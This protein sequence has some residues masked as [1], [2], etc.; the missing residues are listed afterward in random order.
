MSKITTI[1]E[2]NNL[3][4]EYYNRLTPRIQHIDDERVKDIVVC[5]GS[6]CKFAGCKMIANRFKEKIQEN[7]LEDKFEVVVTGCA[8]FCEQGP[9]AKISYDDTLYVKLTEDLVD[10]IIEEHI[11]N[12]NLVKKAL[13]KDATTKMTISKIDDIP[14]YKNQYR[15][16]LQNIGTIDP[17]KITEYIGVDGYQGFAK[18]LLSMSSEDINDE[19]VRSGLQGRGSNGI[20]VGDRW[21]KAKESKCSNKIVVCKADESDPGAYLQ[22][23]II[24]GNPHSIIEAILICGKAIGAKKGVVNIMAKHKKSVDVFTNA[25]KQAREF[26]LLGEN[27]LGCD[28]SFDIF[29]QLDE[30]TFLVGEEEDELTTAVGKRSEPKMIKEDLAN[31]VE[32]LNIT[33]TVETLAN[34]PKI[35]FEGGE[36]FAKIGNGQG[37]GTKVFSLTG[38]INNVGLV[39]VPIGTTLKEVIYN[40]GGGIKSGRAFKAIQVGGP[41]GGSLYYKNLDTPID[42]YGVESRNTIMGTGGLV[43]LDQGDCIINSAKYYIDY[44]AEE[45]CGKCTACRI[46]NTRLSE[47]LE[48]ITTGKSS[49]EEL[50]NLK[51][52]GEFIKDCSLC[53]VGQNSP[54]PVLSSLELFYD[55]YIEHTIY[56]KC[57]SGVC[58]ELL[59]YDIDNDRCIGC[60]ICAKSCPTECISGKSKGPHMI[61]QTNC[62]K[63]GICFS[64]CPKNAVIRI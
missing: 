42:F 16:V 28:F 1:E 58:R 57:L 10:E 25:L 21:Q 31:V 44:A 63:C 56:Q 46:G 32:K 61:E 35:I 12:G 17:C 9:I 39:E 59:G 36:S 45:S 3:R 7:G 8:G 13:Y 40:I 4:K 29:I 33:H 22:R 11:L 6:G 41:T 23:A 62:I 49:E 20:P 5:G 52:L 27:I 54:N 18:A 2:L 14:F 43:V 50:I 53:S 47:M 26:G 37:N 60:T 15:Y 51:A 48:H 34:I 38:K 24:E 30:R 19:V 64:K 55:E